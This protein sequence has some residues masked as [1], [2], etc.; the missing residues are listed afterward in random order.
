M[1][2]T[3]IFVVVDSTTGRFFG[4]FTKKEHAIDSIRISYSRMPGPFMELLHE[5]VWNTDIK[6]TNGDLI[7]IKRVQPKDFAEHL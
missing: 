6:C 4:A 5:D 7:T 2:N 3:S 1:D